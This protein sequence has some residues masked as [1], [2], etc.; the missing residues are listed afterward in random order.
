[1]KIMNTKYICPYIPLTYAIKLGECQR[2]THF[3]TCTYMK[4]NVLMHKSM[5]QCVSVLR[6]Y[7]GV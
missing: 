2:I 4:P 7:G 5:H 6:I 3:H 1:M